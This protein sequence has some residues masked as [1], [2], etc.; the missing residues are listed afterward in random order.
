M[1]GIEGDREEKPEGRGIR[2]EGGREGDREEKPEGRGIRRRS[3]K[4]GG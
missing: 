3:R 1:E 4:G 2:G